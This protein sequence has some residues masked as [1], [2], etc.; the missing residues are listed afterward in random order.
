MHL[1]TT[2]A[3]LWSRTAL[4]LAP[5]PQSGGSLHLATLVL[6]L[7]FAPPGTHPSTGVHTAQLRA[8]GCA[9]ID[10]LQQRCAPVGSGSTKRADR[11]AT[12][13]S[14]AGGEAGLRFD[15]APCLRCVSLRHAYRHRCAAR[16]LRC[17]AGRIVPPPPSLRLLASASSPY[18][19]PCPQLRCHIGSRPPYNKRQLHITPIQERTT[20]DENGEQ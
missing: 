15:F 14:R 7:N 2:S 13:R 20:K 17:S 4:Q 9:S 8:A 19:C 16:H 1:A 12:L 6:T 11:S 5:S 10:S 3:Q 18:A